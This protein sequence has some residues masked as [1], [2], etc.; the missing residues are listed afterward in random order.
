MKA[1]F[2]IAAVAALFGPAAAFPA[3]NIM[4]L[5]K[6]AEVLRPRQVE[7]INIKFDASKQYVSNK[8]KYAF[9]APGPNDQRGP[10]PGLNA[11]AN[12]GYIPHNGVAT[13]Q[14]FVDGTYDVFGMGVDLGGFLAIYGAVFD[15]DLL[16]WSIGGPQPASL[17]SPLKGILGQPQGISGSHNKYEGDASPTRG[18]LF[19]VGD[20]YSVVLDQFKGLYSLQGSETEESS[21]YDLGVLT[22]YRVKRFAESVNKNPYFFNGPFSGVEVQP[23]AYTFIYRFMSNKSTEFP[24]GRLSQNVL[25]AF[26]SITGDTP[27]EFVYTPG[28]EKIPDN[29]YKRAI[30]DE[31]TIPFFEADLLAAAVQNPQFLSIGGNTGKV[32]TFTPVDIQNITGGLYSLATFAEPHNL[33][34]F[35]YQLVIQAGPDILEGS[36]LDT[37]GAINLLKDPL[38]KLVGGVSCPTLNK[39]QVDQFQDSL[40]VH[41]N[42]HI[43]DVAMASIERRMAETAT[44]VEVRREDQDSINA[45]SRLNNRESNLEAQLATLES[46]KADLEEVSSELELADEDEKVPYRV[47]DTFVSLS[48]DKVQELLQERV[49]E[50]E[51]EIGA[52]EG[53]LSS[54]REEMEGLKVKLY[55]RFGKS[56]NLE[57]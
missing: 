32:N 18:D 11:M 30:G 22:T 10:C 4:D 16:S 44:E 29:W 5:P 20:D 24:E 21:N 38:S 39:V 35:I 12:H 52:V 14:Q 17:V 56:I 34:C 27:D 33:Q 13:I 8:G 36:I 46:Q 37:L 49:Q 1:S 26:F 15:G 25:K 31:Y 23:A 51:K 55:A 41:P 45:F 9:V 40:K 53:K 57:R 54:A 43:F 28:H 50:V 2:S 19:M 3:M 7:G 47:G 42:R 6:S 48:V